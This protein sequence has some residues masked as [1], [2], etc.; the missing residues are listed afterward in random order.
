[1]KV[2]EEWCRSLHRGRG[3]GVILLDSE[4]VTPETGTG[5]THQVRDDEVQSHVVGGTE[6]DESSLRSPSFVKDSWNLVSPSGYLSTPLPP[7]DSD[8]LRT[9]LG[10][11]R[12]VIHPFL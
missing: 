9:P 10:A 3:E 6:R 2:P 7:K 11:V 4:G 8:T 5:P 1:M 12:G